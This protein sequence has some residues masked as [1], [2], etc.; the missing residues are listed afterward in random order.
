MLAVERPYDAI[1]FM[2]FGGPEGPDD[3][4][5][6][7]ENVTRGRGVPRERLEEV[8]EQYAMFGGKSPINDQNRALIQAVRAELDRHGIDLPIYWGNRNWHPFVADA[9][10]EMIADGVRRPLAF[11]TSAYSTYSGC[12]Q[13]REDMQR[14]CDAND[15]AFSIDKIR[16]FWHHPGFIGP[17][18][19]GVQ[20]ALRSFTDGPAPRLVF[21][22]HSIPVSMAAT[23]DYQ[24]QLADA[25]ELVV[26]S[27][28]PSSASD[29]TDTPYD[30]VFQ[31]RSGPPQVPW[32]EPDI[33]DHLA[34]LAQQGVSRVVVVPIGFI[35]DHMEVMFDLDTQAAQAAES[36]GITMVRSATP[37]LHPDF[38]AMIRE[39]IAERISADAEVRKL[40][41]L[42]VRPDTC[43][44]DC[45]PAPQRPGPKGGRD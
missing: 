39:L 16:A 37:G 34:A 6:F 36:L 9:V 38:V 41:P 20:A 7:L 43:P 44:A 30:I 42:Q 26:R 32:L 23:C 29:E 15:A 33:C 28:T 19:E 5:E 4:I 1:L 17:M 18:A 8:A 27:L 25:A 40:G 35:S 2:S 13:Y 3:V 21:V 45:C 10:A 31:S 14:A 22:A 12:R 11:V 24:A